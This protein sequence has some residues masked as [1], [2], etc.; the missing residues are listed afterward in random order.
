MQDG[1]PL[2]VASQEGIACTTKRPYCKLALRIGW[3]LTHPAFL[4]VS[5]SLGR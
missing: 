3:L 4:V 5:S 1:C 2:L